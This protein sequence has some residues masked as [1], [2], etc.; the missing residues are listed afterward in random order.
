M[1]QGAI[2]AGRKGFD[3]VLAVL[4]GLIEQRVGRE[5]AAIVARTDADV[6]D[7]GTLIQAVIGRDEGE[8]LRLALRTLDGG[9][10]RQ[11]RMILAELVGDPRVSRPERLHAFERV[12]AERARRRR[13]RCS[14]GW[15]QQRNAWS[16]RMPPCAGLGRVRRVLPS[17]SSSPPSNGPMRPIGGCSAP[18]T[19]VVVRARGG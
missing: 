6:R 10:E 4:E 5:V 9:I 18:A 2:E 15:R 3:G 14:I 8:G 7:L 16:P 17:P 12:V 13:R 11:R 1:P 19:E